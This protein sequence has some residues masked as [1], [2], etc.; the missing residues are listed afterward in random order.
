MAT[1]KTKTEA[2]QPE[3]TAEETPAQVEYDLYSIYQKHFEDQQKFFEGQQSKILE[4]WTAAL[5]NC[6]WWKK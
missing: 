4:Y 5:N 2:P 6:W 3:V 1:K